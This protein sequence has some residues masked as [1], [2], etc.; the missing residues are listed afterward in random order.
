[1]QRYQQ[2]CEAIDA[3]FEEVSWCRKAQ[4]KFKV[5]KIQ[6]DKSLC[7]LVKFSFKFDNGAK[8][9]KEF[10]VGMPE[11]VDK[12]K[13]IL[14]TLEARVESFRNFFDSDSE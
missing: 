6:D 14:G 10:F 13:N 3:F 11:H 2:I 7:V 12:F 4:F 5:K 9:K 1:M 8:Q